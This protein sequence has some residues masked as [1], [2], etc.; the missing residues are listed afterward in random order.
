MKTRVIGCAVAILMSA[1]ASRAQE[2]TFQG[3]W[4]L[5]ESKSQLTGVTVTIDK[6]P[7]G[8]LHF[9]AQGFAYDFDLEG[10]EHP[11]PDGST[12]AWKQVNPTTWE[13]TNRANGKVISTARVIVK[14]DTQEVTIRSMKAD[15][16]S[17]DMTLNL[18]RVSGGPG[19]LGKWKS[20]DVK[21]AP[22]ALQL[23]LDGTAGIRVEY[24]EM[25][26]SCTGKFDGKDHPAMVA[27]AAI[28]QTIA[29]ERQGPNAFKM[30]TKID[31]KPYYTEVLTLSADGK[32]LTD[33]GMPVAVNEPSKAVYERQ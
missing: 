33:E 19:L 23:S 22:A 32:T 27:G 21:G 9:D 2:P 25:Q 11:L 3:T 8:L 24:P 4:K 15:G 20:T 31:G 13:S 28:K 6:K 5:N 1:A 7:S 29:F 14:G 26:M 18:A 30:I 10:K 16:T 12:T 17:S